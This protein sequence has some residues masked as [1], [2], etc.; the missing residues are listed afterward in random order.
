LGELQLFNYPNYEAKSRKAKSRNGVYFFV[1]EYPKR[2]PDDEFVH[3]LDSYKSTA[4][5]CMTTCHTFKARTIAHK[6]EVTTITT[7]ITCIAF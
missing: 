7:S 4:T 5:A 2:E 3:N 1:H 6:R